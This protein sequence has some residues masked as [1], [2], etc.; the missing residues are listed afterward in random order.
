MLNATMPTIYIPAFNNGQREIW[1]VVP[2][3]NC[4]ADA[5]NP[6]AIFIDGYHFHDY[7]MFRSREAA[8]RDWEKLYVPA[9]DRFTVMEL[10]QAWKEAHKS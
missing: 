3:W 8:R 6:H 9:A 1:E 4:F 5:S 2:H 7:Q 10:V